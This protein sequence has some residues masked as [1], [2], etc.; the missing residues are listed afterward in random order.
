MT[1]S[2]ESAPADNKPLVDANVLSSEAIPDILDTFKSSL[3]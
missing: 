3:T 1:P 2:I